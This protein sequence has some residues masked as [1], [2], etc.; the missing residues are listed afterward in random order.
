MNVASNSEHKSIGHRGLEASAECF[1]S[2]RRWCGHSSRALRPLGTQITLERKR[3]NHVTGLVA[4]PRLS[5]RRAPPCL[6]LQAQVSLFTS[7]VR[8][9][10]ND[11]AARLSSVQGYIQPIGAPETAP[12]DTLVPPLLEAV[13]QYPKVLTPSRSGRETICLPILSCRI[14]PQGRDCAAY[15]KFSS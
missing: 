11:S 10:L 7:H 13:L 3:A 1:K 8:C 15:K 9:S 2:P 5:C 12:E 4:R 14:Y 6:A